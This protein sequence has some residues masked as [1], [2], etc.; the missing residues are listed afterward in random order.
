MQSTKLKTN[1]PRN[2]AVYLERLH[3]A[4]AMQDLISEEISI[5]KQKPIEDA[6]RVS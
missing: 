4:R 2:F 5:S 1:K 6:L 3:K